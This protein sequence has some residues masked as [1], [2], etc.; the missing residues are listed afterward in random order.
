MYIQQQKFKELMLQLK[1]YEAKADAWL[2]TVPREI[3]SVFFDNPYVDALHHTKDVLLSALFDKPLRDEVDWFLY[4]WAEDKDVSLR[5]I[6]YPSG[7][8]YVINTL[9][10]FVNYLLAEGQLYE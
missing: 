4:E 7:P 8:T 6:S 5:T 9:D 10:D 2:D 3:N 1:N